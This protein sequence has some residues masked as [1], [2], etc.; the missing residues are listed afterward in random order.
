MIGNIKCLKVPIFAFLEA[1]EVM[2]CNRMYFE[3]VA[4]YA[5]NFMLPNESNANFQ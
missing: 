4:M 3:E 5:K 2:K 1:K